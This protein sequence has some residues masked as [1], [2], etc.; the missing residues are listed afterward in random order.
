MQRKLSACTDSLIELNSA[1]STYL[2]RDNTKVLASSR[3]CH[4]PTAFDGLP[5]TLVAV[6]NTLP[7]VASLCGFCAMP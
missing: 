2:Y 1:C 6:I 4:L 3:F 7:P 5:D